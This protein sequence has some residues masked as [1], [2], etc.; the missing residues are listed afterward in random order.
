MMLEGKNIMITGCRKGIGFAVLEKC[1]EYGANRIWAHIR[2]EDTEWLE[3]IKII[4]K[5]YGTDIQPVYFDLT[6][7]EEMK[8]N[9]K[10][11]ASEK[12]QVDGLVNNAGIV[13]EN[14]SFLMMPIEQI[15][16]VF[17]V[18][19]FAQ[20]EM[21][22]LIARIMMRKRTGSIVNMASVAGIDGDPAQYDYVTSKAAVI[23]GTKKLARELSAYGIR[24]NAVAPGLSDTDMAE[25][26]SQ[27]MKKETIERCMMKR[28]GK[29]EEA[30]E[31]VAFLLSDR[32]SFITGQV[33]RVDG[34][35]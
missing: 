27:E 5:K 22:Q 31:A 6:D 12:L 1:A 13:A 16:D 3:K 4:Q 2:K 15:K 30:A 17:E 33:L 8:T 25:N 23:G 32:S 20:T 29:P 34:G 24:V 28:L 14:R 10:S 21:N 11:I 35:I 19:F 26:M 9:I 7:Y 18:N